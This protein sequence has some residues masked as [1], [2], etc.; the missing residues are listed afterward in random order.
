MDLQQLSFIV[1]RFLAGNEALDM[2]FVSK[3]WSSETL[4]RGLGILA[5]GVP[6]MT[7]DPDTEAMLEEL[8]RLEDQEVS[9]IW[10]YVF[11]R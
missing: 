4:D 2:S 11:N 6:P 3:A 7:Q 1:V 10:R 9:C 8:A 5:E